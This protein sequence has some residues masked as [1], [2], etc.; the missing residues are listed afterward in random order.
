M[1]SWPVGKTLACRLEG[2]GIKS[3]ARLSFYMISGIQMGAKL[4]RPVQWKT[5]FDFFDQLLD[6]GLGNGHRFVIGLWSTIHWIFSRGIEGN[7]DFTLRNEWHYVALP[8][9]IENDVRACS[10]CIKSQSR[11]KYVFLCLY[12]KLAFISHGL[13][14]KHFFCDRCH[15]SV[16]YDTCSTKKYLEVRNNQVSL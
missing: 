7:P 14:W 13:C 1:A 11:I 6:D 4:F 5:C 2:L 15:V 8:I 3:G 10:S 9:N 16:D 12:K